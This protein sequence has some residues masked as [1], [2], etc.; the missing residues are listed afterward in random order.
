MT[1][2][3]LNNLLPCS[4]F[5]SEGRVFL[6]FVVLAMQLSL[7]L[8]PAAARWAR[9][10]VERSGVDRLLAELSDAYALPVDPY[11]NVHKKFRQLA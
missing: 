9:R 8:W 1:A 3:K 11:Q 6:G 4:S 5:F 10:S 2:F 7:V